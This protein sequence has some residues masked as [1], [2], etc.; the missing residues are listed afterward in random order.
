M[1]ELIA[2]LLLSATPYDLV[3]ADGRVVDGTGAPWFRADV[4]IRGDRIAAIGDLGSA[5]TKRRIDVGGMVIAPGFIDMLNQSE[6]GVLIDNRL[7]SYVRQGFT[8]LVC[9]EG[10]SIAPLNEAMVQD[11]GPL[12]DRFQLK[13]DWTDLNGFRRRFEKN[14]SAL[15][16][17]LI[18]GA[19]SLREY[20]LGSGDVQPNAQQ[21]ERMVREVERA[22]DQG[23]FGVSSALI[24]PP[25]TYAHTEE[26]IALAAAAAR[27]GGSYFTHMRSEA[28]EIMPALEEAIRVGREAKIPV[29]IWHLKV[30][31][32]NNHGRMKE[33]VARIEQA[34]REGVDVTADVYPY[35]AAMN[36]LTANIPA[37]AQNGGNAAMLQRIEDPAT[38]ARIKA[39]LWNGGLG[40]ET[41]DG[42][43]LA[44]SPAPEV[45]RF[46]GKRLDS[47]AK[48]LGR[49]PEDALLDLVKMS[50][51]WIGVVRFVM[52]EK[53]LE[54]A[55]R[56]RWVSIGTDAGGRALDGPFAGERAHPRA[57]GTAPRVLGRYVR[58]RRLLAMEEAVR[59]MTSLPA[60]RL[61][62]WDRGLLRPGLSAD[63]VV[64][65]PE[66]IRDL[67]TFDEPLQ[68]SEGVRVLIVNGRVVMEGGK[69]TAERPGRLLRR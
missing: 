7:E 16:F 3:L 15:N 46:M 29:E 62:M 52:D 6:L 65:D 8:T 26:L 13:V 32:K 10:R 58:E 36:G 56:Q 23:A 4:G 11:L 60:R 47:V 54:L 28:D 63:I 9:G 59:K 66:T 24:Y 43:L 21:L 33:V 39:E 42:I 22:M 53:D 55:L 1:L 61:R 17:A 31:G 34:R 44:V 51:G 45:Q 50:K 67:A 35:T 57:F 12:L 49:T 18:V 38:R 20:V 25:S 64:F 5:K 41:P 14:R 27:E 68:Y 30:A 40:R 69:L 48:E 19:T 2:A 37:W